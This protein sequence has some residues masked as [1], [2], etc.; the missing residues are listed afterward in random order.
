MESCE[1]YKFLSNAFLY[2]YA[3]LDCIIS[4]TSA[5]NLVNHLGIWTRMFKLFRCLPKNGSEIELQRWFHTITDGIQN[6]LYSEM[7]N[8]HIVAV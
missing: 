3:V 5:K 7:D 1:S 4:W 6:L 2:D 8:E